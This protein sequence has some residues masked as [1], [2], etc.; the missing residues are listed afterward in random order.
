MRRRRR[1]IRC[2]GSLVVAG[3]QRLADDQLDVE[4]KRVEADVEALAVAVG[5]IRTD[6]NPD[7]LLPDD[8]RQLLLMTDA[9]RRR[10]GEHPRFVRTI[11]RVCGP[12]LGAS[13]A[14]QS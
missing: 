6:A 11:R 8:S 4:G 1:R 10:V 3:R 7:G 9:D 2:S 5:T 12:A 14:V 13:S